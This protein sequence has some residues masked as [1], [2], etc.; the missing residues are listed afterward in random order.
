MTTAPAVTFDGVNDYLTLAS[1]FNSNG[2]SKLMAFSFWFQRGDTGRDQY[3]YS[4]KSANIF[5]EFPGSNDRC[6]IKAE[7][8]AGS[9]IMQIRTSAITDTASLHHIMGA[10]DTADAGKRHLYVDGVSDLGVI[11]YTNDTMDFTQTN[12]NIGALDGGTAL[13]DMVMSEFWMAFGQYIDLSVE[14][15]RRKFIT[16]DLKA[17]NLGADGST[18]TGVAPTVYLG[19][20]A[21][22]WE[23]NLGTGGGFTENGALVSATGPDLALSGA[24]LAAITESA[25]LVA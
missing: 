2:D 9:T 11:T 12:H 18:P 19:N 1:D 16:S 25:G 15:N 5:I 22:S 8:A 13:I 10:V 23:T 3:V 7:N 20:P 24:L 6:V 17:V 21:A 4:S 14:S